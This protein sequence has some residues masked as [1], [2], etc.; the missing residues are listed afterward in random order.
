[1]CSI[2]S[3]SREHLPTVTTI[4]QAA[5]S[6]SVQ[7]VPPVQSARDLGVYIDSDLTMTTH[8]SHVLSSCISAPQHIQPI[9]QSLPPDA[10]DTLVT[11]LVRRHLDSCNVAFKGLLARDFQ[12]PQSVLNAAVRLVSNSSSCCHDT[13]L[14]RDWHWLPI[15]QRVQYKLCMPVHRCLYREASSCLATLTVP[16]A[17]TGNRP[18]V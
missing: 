11:S 12:R 4:F 15:G 17:I 5:M 16:T 1:M 6:G 10:L 9:K 3:T 18:A 7:T 13:S 14:L 2:R 8:I